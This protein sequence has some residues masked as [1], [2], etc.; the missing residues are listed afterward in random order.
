MT[1][2]TLMSWYLVITLSLVG[3]YDLYAVLFLG[4]NST[5]SYEIYS[6]GL[7]FPTLYLLIGMLIG[8]IIFPLHVHG[9]PDPILAKK[10]H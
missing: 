2:Q 4:G 6:L 7:K 10:D 1:L 8:H 3:A 9:D 5:V